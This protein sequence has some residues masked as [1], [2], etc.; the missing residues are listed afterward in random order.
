VSDYC[1][2]LKFFGI[3]PK[4]PPRAPP[5]LALHPLPEIACNP[6]GIRRKFLSDSASMIKC[7]SISILSQ[8]GETPPLPEIRRRPL[9]R[10]FNCSASRPAPPRNVLKLKRLGSPTPPELSG[11][12]AAQFAEIPPLAGTGCWSKVPCLPKKVPKNFIFL[13]LKWVFGRKSNEKAPFF[14]KYMGI[15]A[16]GLGEG[17]RAAGPG[18]PPLRFLARAGLPPVVGANLVFAL[19]VMTNII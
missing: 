16:G 15:G 4:I 5:V 17:V 12:D 6:S 18:A 9:M 8:G 1:P 10:F 7:R 13:Q 3:R 19:A 14:S 11:A 2:C